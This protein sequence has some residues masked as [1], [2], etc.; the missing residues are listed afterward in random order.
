MYQLSGNDCVWVFQYGMIP[1]QN[2]CKFL[3]F[4]FK[5]DFAILFLSSAWGW[6]NT[7]P[8]LDPNVVNLGEQHTRKYKG[9]K[10]YEKTCPIGRKGSS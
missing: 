6:L 5:K 7:A 2:I 10:L 8:G 3:R 4:P 9:G 1:K